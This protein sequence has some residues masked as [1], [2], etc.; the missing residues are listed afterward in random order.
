MF[1]CDESGFT[2]DPIVPIA[3]QPVFDPLEIPASCSPKRLNVLGF[4]SHDNLLNH[5]V[6]KVLSI[7]VLLLLVFLSLKDADKKNCCAY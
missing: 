6:T 7:P 5:Y 2:L 1:H 3:Y 4:L